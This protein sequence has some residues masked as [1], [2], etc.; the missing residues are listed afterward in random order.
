[1]QSLPDEMDCMWLH[2]QTLLETHMGMSLDAMQQW[3]DLTPADRG[4]QSLPSAHLPIRGFYR[5]KSIHSSQLQQTSAEAESH[6]CVIL[7]HPLL[8]FAEAPERLIK[9]LES[10]KSRF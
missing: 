6:Q 4:T 2:L 3:R 8:C 5:I 10:A 9:R 7:W 1:M